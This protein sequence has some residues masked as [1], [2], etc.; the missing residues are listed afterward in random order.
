MFFRLIKCLQI[1]S[2]TKLPNQQLV[3]EK[4]EEYHRKKP[5]EHKSNE[6]QH[7]RN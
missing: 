4:C 3:D 7:L 1:P 6:D 2:H 5:H